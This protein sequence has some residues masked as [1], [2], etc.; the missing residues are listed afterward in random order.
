MVRFPPVKLVKNITNKIK[1][2]NGLV[3]VN[4]ITTGM[5]RTGKWFGYQHYGL[6]PDIISLGKGL[7]NGYPVSATVL[8]R[9]VWELLVKITFC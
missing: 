1:E 6:K 9:Q 3:L 2:N 4:E 5:G 7:G 8:T